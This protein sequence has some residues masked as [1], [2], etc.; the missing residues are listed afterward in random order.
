MD[1]SDSLTP[2]APPPIPPAQWRRLAVC[3]AVVLLA[4]LGLLGWL[5]PVK[6]GA[7]AWT[8]PMADGGWM[9]WTFPVALFFWCI[10]CLLSTFTLLA[11]RAQPKPKRGILRID[12]TAGDRL[13]ISLLGSAFLCL[14]FLFFAGPP[15][16][17]ALPICL[18]YALAVFRW[19]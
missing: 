3:V 17:W 9:A 13:F 1:S 16:W 11:L 14:A 18:V 6:D 4:A 2:L 19:V 10:A 12:T 15:V 5:T 8:A 7:K